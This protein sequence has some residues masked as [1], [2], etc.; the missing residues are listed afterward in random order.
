MTLGS[1][2][3]FSSCFEK[4]QLDHLESWWRCV[5]QLVTLHLHSGGKERRMLVLS[6]LPPLLFFIQSQD[7]CDSATHVH[8]GLSFSVK[9]LY[10]LTLNDRPRG[11]LPRSLRSSQ[12]DNND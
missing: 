1:T 4:A 6:W 5:R 11:V 2:D 10:E 3:L 12:V 9:P 7:L 8:V